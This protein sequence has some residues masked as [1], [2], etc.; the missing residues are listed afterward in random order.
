MLRKL[1]LSFTFSATALFATAQDRASNALT[2]SEIEN[3]T[4]VE[5]MQDYRVNFHTVVEKFNA[6]F[7]GKPYE[8]GHGWKQFKRWEYMM[9]Q[10]VGETGV[11]PHP[12]VL[13]QA[14]Q[15]QQAS[16]TTEYGE[17]SSMGPFNAPANNGIGRINGVAFHPN[18]H[19]TIY[20]G[21]PAGGLWVSYDD[22]QSWTTFTDELTNLGVSDLAID[23]LHPDTMYLATGDRDAADTY[24][25]GLLKSTDGGIT[26]NSTS[27]SWSTSQNY[28]IARIVVHPDS[29]HIVI[30]A[31]NGGIYRS[32]NYGQNFTLEQSGSFYGMRMGHG[33]T[34]FATT[35]GS[36]PKLYRSADAGDTWTQM[37]SGLP[38]NGKYRCEVAVSATPGKVYLV[39]GSSDYGFGGL[40]RST[41]GGSNWTLMSSTP[42]IMG[43]SNTGTGSG[44]QAWY[45]LTIAC[46]PNSENTVYVGGVNI[47]KSTNGGANWTCVGHWYG[48]G[49]TPFVHA[50][51]HHADF[52]PGTSE[53]YAA[54]DGG[55]FKT[56][57]AGASWDD[58]IYGMNI[59]Q[60]YKISQST[61]D[62]SVVLAGAQDN[63]S[64]L[65]SSTMNWSRA[66]GG[67]GMDNGVDVVNDN[68]MYTSIYYGDFY[69]STNGGAFFSSINTLSVAG[70]GNWVTP[71][72]VDPVTTNT[73][74]AG[75]K[76]IWK[77][78]NAG[79][80]WAATSSNNISG[81]SNIDEFEVAPSNTNYIYALINS[82]IFR[83]TNGGSS[84]SSITP[85]G[86]MS[87]SPNN[88]SGV[89]IDPDDEDHIVISISGYAGNRKVM[90][91]F[92]AGST[93]T[94]LSSGLPNVPA[95]AVAF[96]G[97]SSD[98]IYVGTDIGMYYT[99]SNFPSWISFNKNLPNVIISD[100]EVYEDDAL[101]RIGTY[102][103]GVWQSPLMSGF[104][105]APIASF[106]ADPLATCS[107][108]D[109][110]SLTDLSGGLPT[111]W[112]W[113]IS[114]STYN[115]VGGTN[116]SSQY[117]KVLFSS[118]GAY[119][120]TLTVSNN[121]GTD[122]TT[123]FQILGVGGAPL[124]FTED[125][126]SGLS[127]WE[128]A[129]PD[130]G[131]TWAS[132]AVNG[133]SPGNTAMTVNHYSYSS[134]GALDE[135]ISP[136][137]DFSNDTLINLEFEYASAYYS[138]GYKDSLKVYVS[139]DC[140]STWDLVAGYD[141]SEASF[142]T[143]GAVTSAFVPADSTY[144]CH[145]SSSVSCPTIDLDAYS[146]S[147]GV[148]IKFVAVNGYGNNIYLD[149]INI[150]GQAQLPPVAAFTGDTAGC[151]GKTL[152]F[153]DYTA[154]TA[155]ARLWSFQ[156]GT[157]S[158]STSANPVV[159]YSTPGTYDVKLVV[160]NAAG[161]DSVVMPNY[162]TIVSA[163]VADI[164]LTTSGSTTLCNG[165]SATF[166]A[167]PTNGGLNP[168][169]NWILNGTVVSSNTFTYSGTFVNNDVLKVEMLSSDDCVANP[170]VAD[171]LTLTVNSLPTVT[172]GSQGYVCE[173]DGPQLLSGGQPLGGVYSGSG[174]VNDSI[175]PSTAG[176]GSHWVYYTYTDATTGCSKTKQRAISVQPAP[177][178]PT[179]SQNTTGE[180]EA[181]T[182]AGTFTYEWLDA[183]MDP[184]SGATG[185]TFLPQSNG[186]YY[187]RIFSNILCSNVSDV[188]SVVNIGFGEA[189]TSGWSVYPNPA[190]KV[191]TIRIEGSADVRLLDAAGRLVYKGTIS[192]EANL[193]VENWARGTYVLQIIT[194]S[195]IENEAIVLH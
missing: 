71:F 83:S 18:H 21:A 16:S 155:S 6:E 61:S 69:K 35:S 37:T 116:D 102:G 175:Y 51:H 167:T 65:R 151:T 63:G 67:D 139:D 20:A 90:E 156:G 133:T 73:I 181:A 49:S 12:S 93:W 169:I 64:H 45:D 74:Y 128:I 85:S 94:N 1:L 39:Y 195:G 81:N 172:L 3:M 168:T 118:T 190:Q 161:V 135:L 72:N 26:W 33:D 147:S 194:D 149:N 103:R 91:S 141:G 19:D 87:P 193:D 55:V 47:W 25:F 105:T 36:S 27:L 165:D 98:G 121:Y 92:N 9:G 144:W 79:G 120:V 138:S 101:I 117:P 2:T 192:G 48:A 150:F 57:N 126:E 80:S 89:A 14:I 191:L 173:L 68:L 187:V 145:G 148:R 42:N 158:T 24:S 23:P 41:N 32:T 29:T 95:T 107:L 170:S 62:T 140:G 177:G 131:I 162:V 43:W 183:N 182:P 154:P 7:D 75:F 132:A 59:T 176:V 66:T 52:R 70:S 82:N 136:S 114:P 84:W 34:V 31:T 38:T 44:G 50:D 113:Q 164:I 40:Y 54:T 30:A 159:T 58:L 124:P 146:G 185:A 108:G 106:T 134:T 180:L 96:E 76:K 10:R 78:T 110:I 123:A 188:Y 22:G 143:A 115:F 109:T 97:G 127:G 8:K 112:H 166:T 88:I 163:P 11:R 137:L 5:A 77:S 99:S 119:S 17:W 152:Q 86:S 129:N 157:P 60:Y 111:A 186:D 56:S 125:F 179:V 15:Q 171:S 174:I 100:I 142:T 160:S 184:I 153:Y 104:T 28:R 130:A 53:L 178:K 46:D 122:D 4:W 13:Y 189:L